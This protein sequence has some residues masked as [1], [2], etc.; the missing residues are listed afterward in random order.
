MTATPEI[1]LVDDDK[2]V[3]FVVR[4]CL[5]QS[6]QFEVAD[7]A[8]PGEALAAFEKDPNR[9]C[10]LI[11]DYCMPDMTGEELAAQIQAKRPEM[12]VIGISG[13]PHKY[14]H[15]ETFAELLP[16][17]FDVEALEA[18]V[19]RLVSLPIAPPAAQVENRI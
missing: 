4:E 2:S 7:F 3:L 11:T 5:R 18:S 16:K 6:G 15:P 19:Q 17:P 14:K 1:L 9:F 8:H 13:T 10:L 12:P